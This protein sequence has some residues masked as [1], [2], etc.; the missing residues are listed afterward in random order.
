M[1]SKNVNIQSY[2]QITHPDVQTQETVDKSLDPTIISFYSHFYSFHFD[3]PRI[4]GHIQRGLHSMRN[5]L[6]VRQYLRQILCAQDIAQRCHCEQS[7]RI[8]V[9]KELLSSRSLSTKTH[10]PVI[11][12]FNDSIQRILNSVVD[13]SVNCHRH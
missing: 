13:H 12:N 7:R 2:F 8:A 6:P 10:S 4:C 9:A 11:C 3:T 5:R 1:H